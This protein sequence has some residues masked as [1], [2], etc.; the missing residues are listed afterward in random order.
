MPMLMFTWQAREESANSNIV[1]IYES[2]Y[3]RG[4][5]CITFALHDISLYELIKRNNFQ[6]AT[7]S[8]IIKS[9]ACLAGSCQTRP[10]IMLIISHLEYWKNLIIFCGSFGVP[11]TSYL[12]TKKCFSNESS[13]SMC[14]RPSVV[15]LIMIRQRFKPFQQIDSI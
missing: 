11:K 6:V 7:F 10:Y 3:F 13:V 2:F 12:E 9:L 15:T 5:L 14:N 4:H 8:L 1:T